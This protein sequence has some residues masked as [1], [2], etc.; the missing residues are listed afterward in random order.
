VP[1]ITLPAQSIT[2]NVQFNS[3]G[4]HIPASVQSATVQLTDPSSQW[5]AS[6]DQTRHIV[7]W[8]VMASTDSTNGSNGTWAW[9]PVFQQEPA[10]GLPYGSRDKQG[11]LPGLSWNTTA[12][13]LPNGAWVRLSILTDAAIALGATVTIN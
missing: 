1:T 13:P 10:P 6:L 5:P 2:A 9:G 8:G 11:A 4:T 12:E 7:V 3:P